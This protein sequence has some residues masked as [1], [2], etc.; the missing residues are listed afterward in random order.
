MQG[1]S[2][3]SEARL[4]LSL[5]WCCYCGDREYD[6]SDTLR[7]LSDCIQ[8]GQ[9]IPSCHDVSE[10][11]SHFSLATRVIFLELYILRFL[12]PLAQISIFQANLCY[13]PPTFHPGSDIAMDDGDGSVLNPFRNKFVTKHRGCL[14]NHLLLLPVADFARRRTREA[15]GSLLSLAS[16]RIRRSSFHD[17]LA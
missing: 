7:L 4:C 1:A 11:V 10:A 15:S 16:T 8:R 2:Q 5:G 13:F 14:P 12:C 3:Q 17:I 9:Q 6:T